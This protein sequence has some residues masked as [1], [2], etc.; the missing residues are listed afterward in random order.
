MRQV[1]NGLPIACTGAVMGAMGAG[2]GPAGNDT[3]LVA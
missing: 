3:G 2:G 1:A